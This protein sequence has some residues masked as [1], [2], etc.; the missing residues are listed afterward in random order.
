[1]RHSTVQPHGSFLDSRHFFHNAT[2]GL[3]EAICVTISSVHLQKFALN[4]LA[5]F[6]ISYGLVIDACRIYNNCII[7]L[8][9]LLP[10]ETMVLRKHELE[11]KLGEESHLIK[12]GVLRDDNPLEES[13]EFAGFLLACR[14]GDLRKCQEFINLGVNINGKD[15]FDYTGLIIVCL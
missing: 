3:Y 6:F 5:H 14:Q 13:E 15:Q 12:T 4:S 7:F 9:A 8:N 2:F 1:M 11:S 10:S